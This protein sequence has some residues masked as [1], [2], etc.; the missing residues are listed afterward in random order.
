MDDRPGELDR[1]APETE[2]RG[3]EQG[4]PVRVYPLRRPEGHTPPVP[5]YSAVLP[6]QDKV[7]V[8]FTGVQATDAAALRDGHHGKALACHASSRGFD[9]RVQG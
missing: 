9:R 6:Q 5:R 1:A 8:L 4:C 3:S 2:A 7:A